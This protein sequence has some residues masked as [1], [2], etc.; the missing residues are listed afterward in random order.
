MGV[1]EEPP[2]DQGTLGVAEAVAEA[3]GDVDV[4]IEQKVVE[5]APA[6]ALVRAAEGADLL[7]VGG[8]EGEVE[9]PARGV[10]LR[11]REVLGAVGAEDDLVPRFDHL[12]AERRQR[13]LVEGAAGGEIS[14][15]QG[16]M[17]DEDPPL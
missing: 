12:D 3:A 11:E 5:D 16:Q 9:R 1:F 4:E 8:K 14:D 13:G 15:A 7:V 6:H 17:V 10:G 2:F